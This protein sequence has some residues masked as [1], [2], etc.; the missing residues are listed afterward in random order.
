VRTVHVVDDIEKD[1][2][3]IVKLV[4]DTGKA[5]CSGE[6]PAKAN[7]ESWRFIWDLVTSDSLKKDDVVISDLYP[8]GYWKQVPPPMLY[9]PSKSLPNDPTNLY[10]ATLD[11]IQ[12]FMRLVP[13][14]DAR[15]IVI[16]YVPN[17]IQGELNIP[18]LANKI[19]D[20]L[21]AEEFEFYEKSGQFA[22]DECFKLAASR[23]VELLE[24]E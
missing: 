17:W 3:Q 16:T 14:R 6:A 23:A 15:L 12:R 22:D 2:D 21:K 13:K 9:Q 18:V 7:I 19:R 1:R 4:A 20:V 8:E 11:V 5:S 24:E 10:K